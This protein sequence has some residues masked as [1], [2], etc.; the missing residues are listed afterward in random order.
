MHPSP[1]L[2]RL[3]LDAGVITQAVLDE[4]LA[5][6]KIDK[7]RLG[8]LLVERGVVHPLELAQLLSRQ[9]SCPWISLANIEIPAEV[10]ALLPA[11]VAIERH[12]V[13]VH[14]RTSGAHRVLYVA[15]DDPT[16]DVSLAY[17]AAAAEL[18]VRAMVAVTSEVAAALARFY[19]G[20]A[21]APAPKPPARASIDTP[22]PPSTAAA[23]S[24]RGAPPPPRPA[25]ATK[26][27][28][29]EPPPPSAVGAAASPPAPAV[30]PPAATPPLQGPSRTSAAEQSP[31]S[32]TPPAAIDDADLVEVLD[33][34]AR[35]KRAPTVLALS[36]PEGFLSECR[37]A[38]TVLGATFVHGGI[39]DAG[40][41]VKEHRPCAII[42]TDDVYAF[43]RTGLNRLALENDAHL[44]VWSEEAGG[45]HLA[46]LLE[47]AI[48]RWGR[49]SYEKGAIID[50]RYELLRDLGDS[51]YGS[52]WQVRNVR[53]ATRS[54][55]ALAVRAEDEEIVLAIRRTHR[56]LARVAHPGAVELRDA[57][58]TELGD[59]YIILEPLEGR[60]LDGLVAARSRLE[61]TEACAIA[62]QVADVLRAA[63]GMGVAHG[64]V[65]AEK[66]LVVRDGYGFERVKLVGWNRATVTEP[67]KVAPK[68][69]IA[70]LAACAFEAMVGRRPKPDD[71]FSALGI[72]DAL[73]LALGRALG[74]SEPPFTTI[75]E[76]ADALAKAAPAAREPTHLLAAAPARR[77]ASE[78]PPA[79]KPAGAEERRFKR[80]AYRTPVRV[81]MPGAGAVDGKSEDI[82]AGGLLVVARST[83][84]V[85]TKVTVR[86]AL[87]VDG[88][89]VAESAVVKW[90]RGSRAEDATGLSAIGV[91]LTAPSE[92]TQRQIARY[93]SL[94]GDGRD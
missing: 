26:R 4:V 40:D 49:S 89:V 37:S 15:T 62:M 82:S 33:A 16:D 18:P 44:V 43:D 50:G 93:V 29:S 8:E 66:V 21:P 42:V 39:P 65:V 53:T 67:A 78:A 35:E 69:D 7:R 31:P 84:A 91:E 60:T 48:D 6:Q 54:V 85:G 92:E 51:P 76:L 79:A 28:E 52:L 68:D 27:R 47:G 9:L 88:K 55:L 11:D 61:A 10:I 70:A 5:A 41:L 75:A 46:P 34:P 3:L 14:I 56:A 57:G 83:I 87:P 64:D 45:R 71:T 36:A 24:Q 23:V 94:M 74:R 86:F 77:A 13:P 2:G 58:I 20:P 19:D 12:A 1:P 38:S 30:A 81:E 32:S 22:V 63:H 73:A 25:A 17:C 72:P 90:S 80:A 59:P